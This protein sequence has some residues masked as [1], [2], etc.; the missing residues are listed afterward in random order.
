MTD[1]GIGSNQ[2]PIDSGVI[3]VAAHAYWLSNQ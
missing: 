3:A 2:S 1:S